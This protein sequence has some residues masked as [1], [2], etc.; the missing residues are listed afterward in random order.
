M[1]S[2]TKKRLNFLRRRLPKL[3]RNDRQGA[4]VEVANEAVKV[5]VTSEEGKVAVVKAEPQSRVSF[6]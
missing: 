3:W 2:G 4:V 6:N 5:Q 1:H